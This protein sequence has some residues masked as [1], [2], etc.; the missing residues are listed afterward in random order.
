MSLFKAW[1][2]YLV[3]VV[4][5][6]LGSVG[7][8]IQKGFEYIPASDEGQLSISFANPSSDPLSDDEFFEVL[9]RFGAQFSEH[10]DVE[11]IGITLGSMQGSFMGFS[12]GDEASISVILTND[13]NMSTVDFQAYLDD[14]LRVDYSEVEY[15]IS[16][17]QQMTGM[18]TGSGM[19][20][21]IHGHELQ[22]LRVQAEA[23]AS[24]LAGIDGIKE[25][26]SGVGKEA[27][28]FKI[29]VDKDVAA[30]YNIFT[31]QVLGAVAGKIAPESSVTQITVD[32]TIYDIFVFDE[33]S[34]TDETEYSIVDIENIIVGVDFGSGMPVTVGQVADVT[35][36]KGL[37]SITHIDGT[38][39]ITVSAEFEEDANITNVSLAA[40]EA[41]ADYNMPD[42]YSY[43]VLG[44]NEE[45]ME[46]V[47]VLLLAIVL[48]IALI[49]M[50]MASQFQSLKYP[51]IIMFTIPLA[52]TGGFAILWLAGMKVSV[53]ALIGLIILVGVVVNNGIVLVDYINQ[54]REQG[55]ELTDALIEAGK[56]RFRPIIMTA[57]TTILALLAM[58]FGYGEGAE[59]MQPMAVTT[60]GGLLYATLLTLFVV[61]IM[62][63]LVTLHGKYI[64]G[65]GLAIVLAAGA[66][67]GFIFLESLPILIAGIVLAV[68]VIVLLFVINPA[69]VTTVE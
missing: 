56:T 47:E 51:F 43:I 67:A 17:S 66:A 7:L 5:L 39:T 42:G 18:L 41:L 34:N 27:D 59:M 61:P 36:E 15:T 33:N 40:E 26:D 57:L 13:R 48:A 31:A 68:L 8:S 53:V 54:L 69:K 29:T 37:S 10:E 14:I 3:V 58:A 63:Q 55:Y 65:F 25:A 1:S 20:V 22:E 62:Y 44:E 45:V 24:L 32:G 46:A 64:F 60:I 30:T 21:E 49:Y 38:R 4:L 9:D 35:V 12:S 28:E 16:G 23:V 50:I 6:F 19:Q 2:P 11:T 52:F